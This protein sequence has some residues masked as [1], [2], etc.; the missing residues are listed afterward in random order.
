MRHPSAVLSV[1]AGALHLLS[2]RFL[3]MLLGIGY[4]AAGVGLLRGWP[5]ARGLALAFAGLRLAVAALLL[6]TRLPGLLAGD[7][8]PGTLR[9]LLSD[10]FWIVL[11]LVLV[12]RLPPPP[13]DGEH[14]RG[15]CV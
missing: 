8:P 2:L 14:G 3:E 5:A 15:G 9:L 13:R 1:V 6:L 4:L 10:L 7:A 12:F 11:N